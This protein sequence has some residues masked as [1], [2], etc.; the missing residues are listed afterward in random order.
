MATVINGTRV[1]GDEVR[2]QNGECIAVP[3]S[4]LSLTQCNFGD[5]LSNPRHIHSLSQTECECMCREP[6]IRE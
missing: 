3:L 4:P 2:S 1:S 5:P 6:Y